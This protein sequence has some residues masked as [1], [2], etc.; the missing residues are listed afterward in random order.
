M[1]TTITIQGTHCESCKAMIEEV[2]GETKGITRCTVDFKTG[3]AEIEHDGS[4]DWEAWKREVESLGEYKV[5]LK[6]K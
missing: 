2:S 1:K 3:K 4:V 5:Q 6:G